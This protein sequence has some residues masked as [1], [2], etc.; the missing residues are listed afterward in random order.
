MTIYDLYDKYFNDIYRFVY[1]LTK[2][3]HLTE[4]IVQETFTRAYLNLGQLKNRPSKAWLVTVSRNLAYDYLRKSKRTTNQAYD[5]SKIPESNPTPEDKLLQEN[6]RETLHKK[7]SKLQEN[8]RQAIIYYHLEELSYQQAAE[9]MGVTVAN[10]KSILFRAR[11]RLK[12]SLKKGR[13]AK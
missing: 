12:R 5:F 4:D 1:S 8:Y 13:S 7:I 2:D 3:Q 11:Q 6:N 10:F 9:K